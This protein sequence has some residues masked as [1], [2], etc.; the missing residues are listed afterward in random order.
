MVYAFV[1][2]WGTNGLTL[3]ESLYNKL[4]AYIAYSQQIGFVVQLTNLEMKH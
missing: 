2:S 3:L 1:S 4:T